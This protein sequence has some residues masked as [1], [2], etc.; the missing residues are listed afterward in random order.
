[1]EIV[2]KG[3]CCGIHHRVN[4]KGNHWFSDQMNRG[5][6]ELNL[7]QPSES[8]CFLH[9]GRHCT[10]AELLFVELGKPLRRGG[11]Q[12]Q[13]RLPAEKQARGWMVS[14]TPRPYRSQSPDFWLFLSSILGDN[15]G[16]FNWLTC[17]Y[18]IWEKENQRISKPA[19]RPPFWHLPSIHVQK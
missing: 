6:L 13:S 19:K 7:T 15:W 10:V 9:T 14:H 1:M 17:C 8:V 16:H 12:A 2:Q 4:T 3:A 18:W 5:D 11:L